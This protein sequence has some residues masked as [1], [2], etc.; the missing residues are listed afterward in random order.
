MNAI[1]GMAH[2][3]MKTALSP[4][5]HDYLSKIHRSAHGLFELLN[6][7][8]N[9][10]QIEAGTLQLDSVEFKLDDVL[11]NLAGAMSEKT[12]GEKLELLFHIAPDV[13]QYLVGDP[14]RF[15]EVLIHLTGNAVKFSESGEVVV[16]IHLAEDSTLF[17]NK[18]RLDVSVEDSGIGMNAEQ[19]ARLFRPFTQVDDSIS[20]Q[21]GGTGLG[22]AICKRVILMMGGDVSVKSR[23]GE[24]TCVRFSVVFDYHGDST[25][26]PV[27]P[28]AIMHGMNVLVADD[29]ARSREILEDM[30][31]GFSCQVTLCSSGREAFHLLERAPDARCYQVVLLDYDM[32][33]LDGF[34]TMREIQAQQGLSEGHHV[35]M[36]SLYESAGLLQTARRLGFDSVFYKPLSPSTL[37]DSLMK[38][39]GDEHSQISHAPLPTPEGET[40]SLTAL[41]DFLMQLEP[42]LRL[43]KPKKCEPIL[44]KFCGRRWPADFQDEIRTLCES[45]KSYKFSI[46]LNILNNIEARLHRDEEEL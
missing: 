1:L 33:E 26:V 23:P 18:I 46:A 9:F 15:G 37:L 8:I 22:L 12:Q 17:E 10:S 19:Q 20:R 31:H 21:Y 7:V 2:V 14:V 13:P 28:P 45:V 41:S 5:Q 27:S 3:A 42:D 4:Q 30:L 16:H 11:G 36:C 6:D 32:P 39:L 38:I 29:N 40:A 34:D 43:R 44:A 24:G 35:L 25:I